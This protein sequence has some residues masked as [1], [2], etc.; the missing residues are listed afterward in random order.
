MKYV[1]GFLT[2]AFI[3]IVP[4]FFVS[5]NDGLPPNKPDQRVFGS[6]IPT[7]WGVPGVFYKITVDGHDYLL[8]KSGDDGS[9]S[10]CH[11]ADCKACSRWL[12]R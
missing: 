1:I 11:K 7:P 2:A 6:D 9:G 4:M 8:W 3:F 10:I 5:C 12:S